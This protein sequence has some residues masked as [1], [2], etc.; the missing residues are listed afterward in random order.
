[1]VAIVT[2]GCAVA[3]QDHV[4][5]AGRDASSVDASRF[6][7]LSAGDPPRPIAPLSTAT[8]TSRRPTFRWELPPGADGAHV[9]LCA[10]R[11]CTQTLVTFDATGSSGRPAV[12]LPPGISFWRLSTHSVSGV[13]ASAS[14][15]WEV[16]VGHASAPIDTSWGALPDVNGDGF[17]DVLV[18]SWRGGHL[19]VYPGSP[20]GAASV[21]SVDFAD[22]DTGTSVTIAGDLDGDGF[23]ETA[24]GC[25]GVVILSGRASGIDAGHATVLTL[26][27]YSGG[28]Y[29]VAGAGDVD[30]DGYADLLV[31]APEAADSHGRVFVYRGGPNGIDR[32]PTLTLEAPEGAEFGL[33][34]A[35]AGDV[36]G[37]HFEDV[38]VTTATWD[39]PGRVYLYLGGAGGLPS[40]PDL[41]LGAPPTSTSGDLRRDIA[42]AG[43][44]DGDGF[45]DVIVGEDVADAHQ[46]ELYF[47][48]PAGL[49][50][51][52]VVLGATGFGHFGLA[53]DGAGDVDGD[54]FSDIVVG[55][56]GAAHLFRGGPSGPTSTPQTLAAP[57]MYTEFGWRLAGAGDVDRDGDDDVLV[58]AV[59]V[60]GFTGAVYVY[61]GASVGLGSTPAL[62]L[63]GRDGPEFYFGEAVR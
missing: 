10:D 52:S 39:A 1:M 2:T 6:G 51:P 18:T 45:A 17:A 12:D 28:T 60:S 30:S 24:M 50:R 40:A 36:N 38:V 57:I 41:T 4:A 35:G 62:T 34:L 5:D 7:A 3:P 21:A 53:V 23:V 63:V 26:P 14:A 37:D 54:G 47:G 27:A 55:D 19:R 58:S 9:Q 20:S 11:A 25:S 16:N 61:A 46:A 15:V 33:A 31:G 42:C 13:G 56:D 22:R 43:D 49:R 32:D 59:N 29:I 44:V 8:V 48:S